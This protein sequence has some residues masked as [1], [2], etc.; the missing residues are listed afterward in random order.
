MVFWE[1]QLWIGWERVFFV[2]FPLRGTLPFAG[3]IGSERKLRRN[4]KLLKRRSIPG[5]LLAELSWLPMHQE[6]L[7]DRSSSMSSSSNA[8]Q[9]ARVLSHTCLHRSVTN[10][11]SRSPYRQSKSREI[12][13][14][15]IPLCCGFRFA[16][17]ATPDV[18]GDLLSPALWLHMLTRNSWVS[19]IRYIR[20]SSRLLTHYLLP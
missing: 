11:F 15:K 13:W 4:F 16:L 18:T 1:A 10:P 8:K 14:T 3:G 6:Q 5:L 2:F 9:L 17:V 7:T 19:H 20:R 12:I